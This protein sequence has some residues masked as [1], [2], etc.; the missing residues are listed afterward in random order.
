MTEPVEDK[1]LTAQGATAD[2]ANSGAVDTTGAT[3]PAAP[4]NTPPAPEK[5]AEAPKE[6]PP[7][8]VKPPE[9]DNT[10]LNVDVWGSTGDPT[11]DAVMEIM[12]NAGMTPEDAKALMYDAVM[13]GDVT[14][15]D[16]AALIEKVGKARA[17]LITAGTE[18]FITKQAGKAA[19][20]LADVHGSVGG[21]DNWK[22]LAAWANTAVPEAELNDYR[23]MID[24]GGAK[25]RFAA[26]ELLGK[27]NAADTNNSMGDTTITPDTIA[28]SAA[29]QLT[30]AEYY[31]ETEAAYKRGDTNKINEIQKARERGR[32]AGI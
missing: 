19:S 21:E 9:E 23:A 6:T 12:Q 30:R 16:Q 11:G 10:P 1:A 17:A 29:R 28:P 18:N 5:A 7:A 26:Q 24:A 13:G 20:I 4:V 32:A 15:I 2:T 31:A 27:F 22:Q 14:K 25:A 8:E 3:P